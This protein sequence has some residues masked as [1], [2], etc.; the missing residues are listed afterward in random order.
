M[1]TPEPYEAPSVVEIDSSN[2][3]VCTAPI[4]SGIE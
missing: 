1:S 3:P 2:G 4:I